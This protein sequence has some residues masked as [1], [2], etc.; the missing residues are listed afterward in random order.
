MKA[1]VHGST[2]PGSRLHAWLKAVEPSLIRFHA[3]ESDLPVVERLAV[4][5]VAQQLDNLMMYPSVR[6]AVATRS[7]R[8]V[9]MYFDISQARVYLVDP[10]RD[11]LEPVR[12]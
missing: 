1:V 4:A 11:C 7:L 2:R 10:E 6:E 12:C 3:G 5:N 9:G 8:L